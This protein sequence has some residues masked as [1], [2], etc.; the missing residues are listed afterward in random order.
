[1]FGGAHAF[2]SLDLRCLCV[3]EGFADGLGD[4]SASEGFHAIVAGL[5]GSEAELREAVIEHGIGRVAFIL[6]L[7]VGQGRLAGDGRGFA[8]LAEGEN[9]L[10]SVIGSGGVAAEIDVPAV[11]VPR[12]VVVR[13]AAFEGNGPW[14]GVVGKAMGQI[15]ESEAS[16]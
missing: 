14:V 6:I 4:Q 12:A 2:G 1:M 7:R 3:N 10:E 16:F 13:S 15:V 8:A 9:V 5:D 11:P